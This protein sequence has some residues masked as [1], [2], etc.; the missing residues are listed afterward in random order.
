MDNFAQAI[1][2]LNDLKAEGVVF[3]YAVGG[4]ITRRTSITRA[5]P[6]ASS[7]PST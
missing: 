3:D 7:A 1:T 2:A 6:F 4:A 5:S